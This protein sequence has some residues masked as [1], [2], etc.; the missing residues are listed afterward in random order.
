MNMSVGD[1]TAWCVG[2]GIPASDQSQSW[3]VLDI[4]AVDDWEEGWLW[5]RSVCTAA[6]LIA[7]YLLCYV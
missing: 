7:S 5:C 3:P 6:S 2:Q 1:R 4:W